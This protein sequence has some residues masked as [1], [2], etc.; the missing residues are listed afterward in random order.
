MAMELVA[1]A[2]APSPMAMELLPVDWVPVP[3][4]MLFPPFAVV[5]IPPELPETTLVELPIAIFP[6]V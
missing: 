3:M 1:E 4:A 2:F 5:R 6:L